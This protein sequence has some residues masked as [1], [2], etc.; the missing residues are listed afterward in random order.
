MILS[1]TAILARAQSEELFEG[2]SKI[3]FECPDSA[4]NLYMKLGKH[5][6]SK[7]YVITGDKDFLNIKTESRSISRFTPHTYTVNSIIQGNRI[8]FTI[9]LAGTVDGTSHTI[10]WEY[11]KMPRATGTSAYKAFISSMAG[12]E[13]S[14]VYYD[15]Y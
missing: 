10:G 4:E 3:I 9:N 14:K 13:R 8:T 1:L 6:I 5:L 7:G 2:A 11:L 15:K 12:F